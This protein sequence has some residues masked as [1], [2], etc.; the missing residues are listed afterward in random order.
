MPMA[1]L[2]RLIVQGPVKPK[3]HTER[4]LIKTFLVQPKIGRRVVNRIAAQKYEHLYASGID[5]GPDPGELD[6]A[7]ACCRTAQPACAHQ[8]EVQRGAQQVQRPHLQP[9]DLLEMGIDIDDFDP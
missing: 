9:D 8:V 4:D 6:V 7:T 3:M 5:V 2:G 1:D